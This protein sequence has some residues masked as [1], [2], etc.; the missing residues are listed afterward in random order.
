M[1]SSQS[2]LFPSFP[3]SFLYNLFRIEVIPCFELYIISAMRDGTISIFKS[4]HTCIS[5]KDN[6]YSS[7]NCDRNF[8]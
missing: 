5:F 4:R 6:G 3:E 7:L 2:L 8:G 1:N